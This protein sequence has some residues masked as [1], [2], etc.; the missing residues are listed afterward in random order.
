MSI[1]KSIV[2]GIIGF[3]L[4]SAAFATI[5]NSDTRITGVITPFAGI[6]V[7]QDGVA[8]GRTFATCG[9]P[10]TLAADGNN[11][12]PATTSVYVAEVFVPA[13]FTSTGIAAFN[14]SDATD[15][16]TGSLYNSAGTLIAQT[17]DT[18][19]SG[20]DAYQRVPWTAAVA[21]KGPGI[22]YLGVAFDGTT[23]R[24]NTFAVG[25]CGA[26]QITGQVY[27]NGPPASITVPTTFTTAL[28]PIASLY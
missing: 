11:S 18:Q 5:I 16:I 22:Y 2:T 25:N 23:T 21:L 10:A 1:R 3:A 20:T 6:A 4:V 7:S 28:G 27:A 24:F 13:N 15:S 8:S 9:T 26:G 19:M 12:T 17:A 14:G